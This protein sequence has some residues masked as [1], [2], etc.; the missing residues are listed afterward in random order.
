MFKVVKNRWKHGRFD[1]LG[2]NFIE[3][4][5]K[6]GWKKVDEMEKEKK[7]RWIEKLFGRG[8]GSDP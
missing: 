1:N 3:T 6:E 4:G 7:R 5:N 2:K 8:P